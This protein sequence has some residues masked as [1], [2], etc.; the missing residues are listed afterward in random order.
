MDKK[1]EGVVR[2]TDRRGQP[3]SCPSWPGQT[4]NESPSANVIGELVAKCQNCWEKWPEFYLKGSL[5]WR[6][7]S[8]NLHG[9]VHFGKWCTE[10]EMKGNRKLSL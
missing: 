6:V 9:E 4:R 2:L 7:R 5:G 3:K 8:M 10:G 1:S